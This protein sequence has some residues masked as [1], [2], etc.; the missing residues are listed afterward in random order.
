[1]KAPFSG[2]ITA[3]ITPYGDKGEVDTQALSSLMQHLVSCGIEGF[4]PLGT[5]GEFPM[6]N[7]DEKTAVIETACKTAGKNNPVIA[8]VWG[9]TKAERSLLVRKSQEAGAR[10]IFLTTPIYYPATRESILEWYRSVKRETT[11]PLVAYNIPQFSANE[12]PIDVLNT[13]ADEGTIHGYKE[14]S[15]DKKRLKDVFR[16]LRGKVSVFCGNE[17]NFIRAYE[18]GMDGFMSMLGN[19]FPK[20]VVAVTKGDRRR[21]KQLMAAL[22]II[23]KTGG[24][25]AIKYLAKKRGFGNGEA[26]DLLPSLDA[27][28]KVKLEQF[29]QYAAEMD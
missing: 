8:G 20:T 19:V 3:T 27:E 22:E 21:F 10:G 7:A 13:L 9:Q 15:P 1:M 6:L 14:S 29:F 24:V 2:I 23:Q 4:L 26:R 25:S 18:M 16:T 11:L 17:A 28:S 12:I 5:T